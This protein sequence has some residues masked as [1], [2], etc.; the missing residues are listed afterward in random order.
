MRRRTLLV[1]LAGPAVVIAAGVGMFWP[2]GDRPGISRRNY[3]RIVQGMP[4]AVVQSMMGEPPGQSPG[5][6]AIQSYEK[7][8]WP[9]AVWTDHRLTWYADDVFVFV[10]VDTSG[11][12]TQKELMVPDEVPQGPVEN[13]LWR[14]KRRWHRWFPE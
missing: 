4:I 5:L 1:A 12:V 14:A 7:S 10:Y 2:L 8:S 11:H 6:Q 3:D 13:L 9:A